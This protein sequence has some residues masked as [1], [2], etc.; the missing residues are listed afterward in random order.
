MRPPVIR[1]PFTDRDKALIR[2]LSPVK[3]SSASAKRLVRTLNDDLRHR[4]GL[5]MTDKQR[6][7]L[8]DLAFK[9]RRQL[10]KA[11]QPAE[12]LSLDE[13]EMHEALDDELQR[14]AH[15]MPTEEDIAEMA[16][17]KNAIRPTDECSK[18]DS[19]RQRLTRFFDGDQPEL[20]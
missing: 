1:T 13:I 5:G 17:I 14:I 2:A 18:L 20:L 9:F 3:G 10:P 11:L 7:W 19:F 8:A 4:E 6:A 12:P 15:L 16:D